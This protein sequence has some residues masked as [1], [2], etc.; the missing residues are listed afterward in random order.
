MLL[1]FGYR[2]YEVAIV[3]DVFRLIQNRYE[4][5]GEG[6]D[7]KVE[8]LQTH[9]QI[10]EYG[11][12]FFGN[13]VKS[14]LTEDT[15]DYIIIP[16]FKNSYVS[17]I[18]EKNK[19]FKDW[20]LAQYKEQ[21]TFL[22]I[23]N[24]IVLPAYAGLLQGEKISIS[25]LSDEFFE[26]FPNLEKTH[27]DHIQYLERMTL[28]SGSIR[29]FYLLFDLLSQY[30]EDDFIIQLAKHYQI[31]LNLIQNRHFEEFE[32]VYETE[33]E[34][35]ET[36]LSK[37]HS[38]YHSIKLLDEVLDEYSESRRSFN[39][40]F[41][42]AT[43]KTPVEYLQNVRIA[44]AKRLLETTEHSVE[45][46]AQKVGYS[47]KKSFRIIFSRITGVLPLEYRKRLRVHHIKEKREG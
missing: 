33:D 20:I 28:S 22:C 40:K 30:A 11:E 31:D 27:G 16:P 37:I 29:T 5:F 34:S 12:Q 13:T 35:I 47:D 9:G 3:L 23:E 42:E 10:K 36:V 8:L 1:P 39:R 19:L 43:K 38:R 26:Y 2:L 14:I 21:T 25:G 7:F 18:A 4:E 15:Y 41:V 45:E 17:E 6:R 44:H 46:I 32:F 24:G